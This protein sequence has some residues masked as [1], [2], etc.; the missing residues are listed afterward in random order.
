MK[1]ST[2][3]SFPHDLKK[4]GIIVLQEW[5]GIDQHIKTTTFKLAQEGY[6]AAAPDLYHGEVTQEPDEAHKLM[7]EK[8]FAEALEEVKGTLELI[9][10]HCDKVVVMGF[11]MGGFLALKMAENIKVDG[12][13]AFYPGGYQPTEQDIQRY[14][15]DVNIFY[16]TKD[17]GYEQ[18]KFAEIKKVY[19]K[20]KKKL[21]LHI[22]EDKEHAFMNNYR[23]SYDEKASE[24]AW[25]IVFEKL[26]KI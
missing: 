10:K 8:D 20:Y 13:F 4:I 1:Y 3:L 25:K 26:G 22:F 2:Y 15:T 16:G 14:T 21:D 6:L 5:W 17:H 12:V 23:E 18:E 19:T 7:M 9:K 11:C 24:E